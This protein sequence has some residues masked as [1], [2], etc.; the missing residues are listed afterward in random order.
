MGAP[1]DE[2]GVTRPDLTEMFEAHH[3]ASDAAHNLEVL[4]VFGKSP[5]RILGCIPWN[6]QL[7][8]PRAK[9]LAKHLA[10]KILHK[11]EL[12]SRR[13]QTVTFCAPLHPQHGRALP[14]GQPAGHLRRPL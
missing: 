4:Q 1:V 8:A 7:I 3:H 12:D 6:T 10:A 5:L 13:L 2:H 9:D 14:S 11:G